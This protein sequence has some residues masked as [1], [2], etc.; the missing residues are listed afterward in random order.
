MHTRLQRG[1]PPDRGRGQNRSGPGKVAFDTPAF[2][3]AMRAW[4][5]VFHVDGQPPRQVY[6]QTATHSLTLASR[7]VSTAQEKLD[8]CAGLNPLASPSRA[9]P[10]R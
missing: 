3:K 10:C 7:L 2:E 9:R 8:R 1:L 6:C 4:K 5:C